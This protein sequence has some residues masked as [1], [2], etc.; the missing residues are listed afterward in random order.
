MS[1]Y[2]P[3][4]YTH[5]VG[6]SSGLSASSSHSFA[7]PRSTPGASDDV[8]GPLLMCGPCDAIQNCDEVREVAHQCVRKAHQ[9]PQRRRVV[10]C[11]EVADRGAAGAGALR[12]FALRK[13][14]GCPEFTETGAEDLGVVAASGHQFARPSP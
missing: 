1:F 4:K 8:A 6:R 10:P 5:L 2:A 9:H 14:G 12:E 3:I 11:F 13:A 7:R